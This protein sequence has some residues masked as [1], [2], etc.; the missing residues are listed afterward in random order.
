MSCA[1]HKYNYKEA[2]L[3]VRTVLPPTHHLGLLILREVLEE[4]CRSQRGGS[5]DVG[6]IWAKF[7]FHLAEL[8]QQMVLEELTA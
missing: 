6:A 7:V 8:I 3:S 2:Q 4:L 5:A 1:R